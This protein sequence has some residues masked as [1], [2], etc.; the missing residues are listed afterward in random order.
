M[1]I[2]ASR[3]FDFSFI[4]SSVLSLLLLFL[5]CPHIHLSIV[6]LRSIRSNL[7][8]LYV[9]FCFI[10]SSLFF[11]FP[12]IRSISIPPT[13]THMRA[14]LRATFSARFLPTICDTHGLALHLGCRRHCRRRCCCCFVG[15]FDPNGSYAAAASAGGH[16]SPS[17][18][19]PQNTTHGL[20][21]EN[22]AHFFRP[23]SP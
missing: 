16:P 2:L 19:R 1:E 12:V 13:P 3:S 11:P 4:F 7:L 15:A 8:F 9:P 22:G 17:P 18:R 14:L 5:S 21:N 6:V 20:P 23:S 10:S